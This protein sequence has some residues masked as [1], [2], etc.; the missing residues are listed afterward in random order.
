MIWNTYCKPMSL[1]WA[2][3]SRLI[4]MGITCYCFINKCYSWYVNLN[5]YDMLKEVLM[6]YYFNGIIVHI[7]EFIPAWCDG[8]KNLSCK[9]KNLLKVSV[10]NQCWILMTHR[11]TNKWS[12]IMLCANTGLKQKRIKYQKCL[13][14]HQFIKCFLV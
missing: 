14:R 11:I 3:S 2:L 7:K 12:K 8:S 1:Y 4:N 9:F 10:N 6:L 5:G 13:E